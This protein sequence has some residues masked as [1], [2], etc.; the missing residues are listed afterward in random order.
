VTEGA[1]AAMRDV[2]VDIQSGAFARRWVGEMEAG[3]DEFRRLRQQD[4]D[5]PIEQVGAA[6][7]AKMPF[8]NPIEVRAGQA[9]A[10]ASEPKTA[11]SA[12]TA[13]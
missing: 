12:G 10:S 1:K 11:G 7:R 2:L 4:M 9:Q 8:V 5:H 6:L 13:R 3:G